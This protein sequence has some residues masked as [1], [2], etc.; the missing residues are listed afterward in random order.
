MFAHI[1]P[2][3]P[4]TLAAVPESLC[5]RALQSCQMNR[6]PL[7]AQMTSLSWRFAVFWVAVVLVSLCGAG[8]ISHAALGCDM[9]R[10]QQ[11]LNS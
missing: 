11:I 2:T 9:P 4:S 10:S 8:R 1:T 7:W 6:W 3:S 5:L